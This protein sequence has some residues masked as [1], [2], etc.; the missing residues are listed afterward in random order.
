[1][2]SFAFVKPVHGLYKE[3][4]IAKVEARILERITDMPECVRTDK[5]SIELLLMICTMIENAIDN[6]G[7]KDKK[8]IDKK[9]LAIQVMTKLFGNMKPDDISSISASIEFL[10]DTTQIVK[11]PLWK[12][13]SS[14]VCS[15]VK[16][17]LA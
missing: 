10:H 13:I 7:K 16:K 9:L 3:A 17:K 11:F 15:W 2:S 12:V 8:K 1:M 4:K 14:N 6:S 5:H